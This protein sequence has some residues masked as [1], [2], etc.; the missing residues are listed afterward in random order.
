M[1][2]M[3][4]KNFSLTIYLIVAGIFFIHENFRYMKNDIL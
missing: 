3:P 1:F 4:I 2:H